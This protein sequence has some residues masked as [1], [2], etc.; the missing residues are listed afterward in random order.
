MVDTDGDRSAILLV[1]GLWF[2][3]SVWAPWLP[4]LDE[5]GY[6]TVTVDWR[7]RDQLR[8]ARGLARALPRRPV[9]IGHGTGGAVAERLLTDGDADAAISLAPAPGGH[10][11]IAAVA[12]LARRETGLALLGARDG[13]VVPTF[14]QFRRTMANA[15]DDT[16]ARN[17]YQRHVTAAASRNVLLHAARCRLPARAGRARR[18]PLLLAVGGRDELIGE[19]STASRYRGYRRYQPDAVTDYKVFPGLD[20]TLGLGN[21]EMDVLFYCLDWLTAQNR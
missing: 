14:S 16:D 11:A 6:D 17:R 19:M 12:R 20:H 2:R 10:L 3:A 18:G 13:T 8:S 7:D 21:Q 1:H 5:A 4:E 9:V 15:S